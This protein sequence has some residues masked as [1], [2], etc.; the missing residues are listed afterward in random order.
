MADNVLHHHHRAVHHH[1]KI[2]R[3]Q[4]EQIGGDPSQVQADGGKQ[5]GKGNRQGNNQSSTYVPQKQ[6]QNNRDQNDAFGKV[7][8][9]RMRGKVHQV[10]AVEE[11]N[12]LHSRRQNMLVQFFDFGVNSIQRVIGL[13][14]FAHQHDTFHYVVVINYFAIGAMNC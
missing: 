6:K 12:N 13:S 4:R 1:A 9:H 8:Q 7:V 14:A 2:Q 10:I 11:G 5:Q 3:A